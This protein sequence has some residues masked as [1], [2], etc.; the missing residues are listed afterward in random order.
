M[1]TRIEARAIYLLE[2]RLSMGLGRKIWAGSVL[3]IKPRH[4]RIFREF[5]FG[6]V[7]LSVTVRPW[8]LLTKTERHDRARELYR[9][10]KRAIQSARLA[11]Q[12][13]ICGR[14]GDRQRA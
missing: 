11:E 8:M 5:R 7:D 6:T 9:T 13:G 1:W 2:L 10:S 4:R 12:Y 3:G 14:D